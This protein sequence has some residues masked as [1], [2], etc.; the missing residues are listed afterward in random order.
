MNILVP[1]MCKKKQQLGRLIILL[2]DSTGAQEPDW[3]ICFCAL[4]LGWFF[5][6][7]GWEVRACGSGNTG[8]NGL[9]ATS[10]PSRSPPCWLGPPGCTALCPWG[11]IGG[12]TEFYFI[13][14]LVSALE[15]PSVWSPLP[16]DI[17]IACFL[18]FWKTFFKIYLLHT[19]FPVLLIPFKYG[20]H[21]YT[22]SWNFILQFNF[23]LSKASCS[24]VD[25][26][27]TI[28]QQIDNNR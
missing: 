19:A 13:S 12:S 17:H 25:E 10:Q 24:E 2:K 1:S 3:F 27:V 9:R 28:D 18:P 4:Q 5:S 11:H 23:L 21:I 22:H 16:L 8:E 15:I 20:A 6:G 7:H 14:H 26:L